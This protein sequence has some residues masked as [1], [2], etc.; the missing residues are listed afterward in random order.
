MGV[1]RRL[2]KSPKGKG[3]SE[4][5]PPKPKFVPG[6]SSLGRSIYLQDPKL[7][8]T[9]ADIPHRPTIPIQTTYSSS[10]IPQSHGSAS[11]PPPDLIIITSWTGAVPK[12]VAKYT[13]SYNQL[14]PQTPIMVITTSIADLAWHRTKTKLKVLAPAVQYL[15]TS[16]N[17]PL[18]E[19]LTTFTSPI[20]PKFTNILLHAFSE[21]GA[22]KAVCLAQAYQSHTQGHRLPI[23]AFIFDSTPGTPRYSSN[24]A[25]FRRSLPRNRFAQAVGLPFG[26]CVLGVTWVV[27]CIVVGYDNNLI[28]KTRRSLNDTGLWEV[29]R[30]IPRTY[31][32]SES[33]DL[34]FWKDVEDHGVASADVNGARSLLV[35]FKSTGHCGHAR[36]NE[37]IYWGAVM[38]TWESTHAH[39]TGFDEKVGNGGGG[40]AGTLGAESE[41]VAG[42]AASV[43][44]PPR[45]VLPRASVVAVA[46]SGSAVAMRKETGAMGKVANRAEA[47]E[48]IGLSMA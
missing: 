34:I 35:R 37:E 6:F 7:E 39:G 10:Q 3:K 29:G 14:F 44:A 24:V 42:A 46:D 48:F 2:R 33:D 31:L 38:R 9:C 4:K 5:K 30:D 19:N 23:A 22:N 47:V 43:S 26:A 32:F 28:S 11:G 25:A 27:F 17:S 40:G 13:Q 20:Q 36:G 15:T 12:H 45:A 21:G 1:S 41:D 8:T 18:S 16:T